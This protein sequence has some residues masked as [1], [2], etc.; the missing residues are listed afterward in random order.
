[1]TN[2]KIQTADL[3]PGCT[4]EEMIE[5]DFRDGDKMEVICDKVTI[6]DTHKDALRKCSR[7]IPTNGPTTS[8]HQLVEQMVTT[9]IFMD[10]KQLVGWTGISPADNAQ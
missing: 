7:C 5:A 1:M 10:A 2:Q 9:R 4:L 6:V 8:G 3:T